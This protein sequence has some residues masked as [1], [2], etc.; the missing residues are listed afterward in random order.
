M[1]AKLPDIVTWAESNFYVGKGQPIQ[2]QP[3]QKTILREMFRQDTN[4]RLIYRD[5]LYSTIKKSG[6]TT[7]AALIMQWA[8]MTWGDEKE[9]YHIANKLTQARGRAFKLV[10]QSIKWGGQDKAWDIKTDKLTYKANGSFIQALPVNASGEAGAHQ[11]LTTWTEA[12][13]FVYEAN[14]RMWE[15]MQPI[16]TEPISFRLM[17]SYAGYKGESNLLEAVWQRA[18]AGQQVHDEY[19]LYANGRLIAYIDE[20]VKARRMPWQTPDYYHDA[21]ASSTAQE[22]AR[23]HLNQWVDAQ[24]AFVELALWDGLVVERLPDEKVAVVLGVDASVSG[25]CSAVVAV[26]MVNDLPTELETVIFEPPAKGTLDYALTIEPTIRRMMAQYHVVGVAY[27]PF[28]MHDLMNRLRKE[29]APYDEQHTPQDQFFHSFGQTQARLRADNDLL[30]RIRQKRMRHS[31]NPTLREH[32]Q[33]ADQKAVSETAIRI[34]KRSTG[35]PIDGLVALSMALWRLNEV[36]GNVKQITV[37]DDT[38]ISD[39]LDS[40]R[41]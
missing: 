36:M 14:L 25:D 7:I 31:G 9:I 20:G 38:T 10:K 2:L 16:P 23:I 28:Q 35:K 11:C 27:D 37:E 30:S 19:P 5:G 21:E 33:N 32:I 22:F 40:F 8:C 39:L 1:T 24:S 41:G 4:G 29:Y 3:I 26:G 17:E 18:K 15:E 6:K 12:H 34:V 13:G